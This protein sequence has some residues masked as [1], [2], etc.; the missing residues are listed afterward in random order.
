MKQLA[1]ILSGL[2]LVWAQL[3]AVPMFV[4][5][6]Q[7]AR[8]CCNCGGKMSCCA[9]ASSDTQPAPAI[10][11]SAGTQNHLL[12]PA[13]AFRVGTLPENEVGLMASTTAPL[14][15]AMSVPLYARD[16]ARLI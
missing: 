16:C 10:P 8:V 6:G 14:S 1:A 11:F 7:P 5:A 9:P 15:P 13:A 3:P 4:C 12:L 2:M